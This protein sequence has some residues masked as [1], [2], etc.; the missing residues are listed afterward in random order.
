VTCHLCHRTEVKN[1]DREVV[2]TRF[3][4]HA[5]EPIEVF[6]GT[7]RVF[8]CPECETDLS[9]NEYGAERFNYLAGLPQVVGA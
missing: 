8:G 3:D 9:L 6:N 7:E 5:I 4:A 1:Y 2:G